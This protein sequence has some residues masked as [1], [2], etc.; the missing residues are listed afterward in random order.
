MGKDEEIMRQLIDIFREDSD[1]RRGYRLYVSGHSLGGALATIFAFHL[2]AAVAVA[3]KTTTAKIESEQ[4]EDVATA[5]G[6][7]PTPII[8]VSVASPRP[9]DVSF[10]SAFRWLECRRYLRH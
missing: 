8:C 5:A 4:R 2:A 10:Q 3:E 9:A 7:I 6:V 1:E